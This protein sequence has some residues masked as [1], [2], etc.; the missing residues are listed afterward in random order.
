MMLT[1]W[2]KNR[3]SELA[4]I[5][6]EQGR[7]EFIKGK[8]QKWS[9]ELYDQ[10]SL[11]KKVRTFQ[12]NQE[13]P[14][15]GEWLETP[16]TLLPDLKEKFGNKL[17]PKKKYD[18]DMSE[19]F[20]LI[21]AAD[22]SLNKQNSQWLIK[23]F[24]TGVMPLEDLGKA[25]EYLALY[26]RV[27]QRI[28]IEKRDILKYKNL[29]DL[30]DTVSPYIQ[31]DVMSKTEKEKAAKLEGADRVYEDNDWLVIH[32]K[33]EPA[34]CLY[35]RDTTWCTTSGQFKYYHSK[36]PLY[37]LFDKRIE[38]DA[39]TNPMK[40]LQF[41]FET[42]QFM[43]ARDRSLKDIGEFFRKNQKL[44]GVFIKTGK[45]TAPFRLEHRL[46][47]K[48][49]VK[50]IL[51]DPKKRLEFLEGERHGHSKY[52]AK[53]IF[54]YLNEIGEKDE[55]RNI[56]YN[57]KKFIEKLLSN[58]SLEE[59]AH[60]FEN[61]GGN[62][63]D[64]MADF[65]HNNEIVL[66]YY[67]KTKDKFEDLKKYMTLLANSGQKGQKYAKEMYVDTDTIY[68]IM[69]GHHALVDY[70]SFLVK[71]FLTDGHRIAL[72]MVN[73]PKTKN[74]FIK[75]YGDKVYNVMLDFIK[76][77]SFESPKGKKKMKEVEEIE[78]TKN[79]IFEEGMKYLQN[80]GFASS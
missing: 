28:P 15:G 75:D 11:K 19:I 58:G 25:T 68:N 9:D 69:R 45:A 43:D 7:V 71:G 6:T 1:E 44:L 33:T 41:H 57:D 35:G 80:I 64:E 22:P 47:P 3:I 4:G 63:K 49:E 40:K 72:D 46:M 29:P 51:F 56:L 32:P 24:T 20:E 76:S 50:T 53:W 23:L 74:E 14:E 62:Y 42:N 77:T 78:V 54:D 13:H 21:L 67:E 39:R 79:S 8:F 73:S 16:A 61:L 36:G 60:G 27:K 10:I 48:E 17:P 5:L 30:Y 70:Y 18:K 38:A 31:A 66:K 52:G 26:E 12:A 65:L 34:A 55:I 37:I 59:V 2:Y